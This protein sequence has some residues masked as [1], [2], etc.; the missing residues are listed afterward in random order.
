MKQKQC[1]SWHW[2]KTLLSLMVLSI[3][4]GGCVQLDGNARL[5]DLVDSDRALLCDEHNHSVKSCADG[6]QAGFASSQSCQETLARIDNTDP[7]CALTVDE[8]RACMDVDPCDRPTSSA[9][10]L[11]YECLFGQ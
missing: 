8:Y 3:T 6:S 5:R 9:C 4:L 10:R 2:I 7:K 1:I 11:F